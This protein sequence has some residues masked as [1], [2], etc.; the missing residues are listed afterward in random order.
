MTIEKHCLSED[1][2]EYRST[3]HELRSRD[4][5]FARLLDEYHETDQEIRR[6]EQ[7]IET[8]GDQY[9]EQRKLRR[10]RLKDELYTRLCAEDVAATRRAS[11]MAAT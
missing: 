11:S 2:P 6:I 7:Q 1:F 8:P 10:V 5:H 9:V 4:A 3:I